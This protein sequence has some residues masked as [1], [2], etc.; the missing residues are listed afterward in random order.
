MALAKQRNFFYISDMNWFVS[1][2]KLIILTQLSKVKRY[3]ANLTNHIKYWNF[4][5]L[6]I[7]LRGTLKTYTIGRSPRLWIVS[8]LLM[9]YWKHILILNSCRVSV[10]IRCYNRMWNMRH[11]PSDVPCFPPLSWII[12]NLVDKKKIHHQ[13]QKNK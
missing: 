11:L 12:K 3:F 7:L 13:R 1:S 10:V 5:Y 2:Y 9:M 6:F 8:R 4:Y